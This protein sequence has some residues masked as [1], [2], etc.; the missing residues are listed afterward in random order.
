MP[1]NKIYNFNKP[2]CISVRAR[3]IHTLLP[4]VMWWHARWWSGMHTDVSE[5]PVLCT[6][7]FEKWDSTILQNSYARQHGVTSQMTVILMLISKITLN[8]TNTKCFQ[9]LRISNTVKISL[10][11]RLLVEILFHIWL[12]PPVKKHRCPFYRVHEEGSFI[13]QKSCTH[14][15]VFWQLN[16]SE[17]RQKYIR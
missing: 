10:Y 17:T 5:K 12:D 11:K 9:K 1:R 14:R 13:A 6:L 7:Y 2:N 15:E 16:C 4:C 8:F 3:I